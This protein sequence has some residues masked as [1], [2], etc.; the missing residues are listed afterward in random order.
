MAAKTTGGYNASADRRR[1]AIAVGY[2][3]S[4]L[5]PAERGHHSPGREREIPVFCN[6]RRTTGLLFRRPGPGSNH[7]VYLCA[8][9]WGRDGLTDVANAFEILLR[10]PHGFHLFKSALCGAGQAG[11]D[12]TRHCAHGQERG[13]GSLVRIAG[14][15]GG[16]AMLFGGRTVQ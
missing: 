9:F 2:L 12:E 8:F 13:Y 11:A 7:R 14:K 6:G 1:L 3:E 10:N 16:A 5:C 15:T 4:F